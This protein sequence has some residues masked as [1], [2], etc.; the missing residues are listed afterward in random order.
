VERAGDVGERVVT[1]ELS[2]EAMS[3]PIVVLTSTTHL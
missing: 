2:I 3:T 1:I